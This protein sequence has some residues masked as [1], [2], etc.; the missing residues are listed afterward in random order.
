MRYRNVLYV[1]LA[2]LVFLF[3]TTGGFAAELLDLPTLKAPTATGKSSGE[4]KGSQYEPEEG[5]ETFG[6][7][8]TVTEMNENGIIIGDSIFTFSQK[9]RGITFREGAEVEFI[10]TSENE[11]IEIKRT[12]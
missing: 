3:F 9:L 6:A 8:G 5:Y 12:R 11:I 7:S 10:Y 4:A 1:A 2:T